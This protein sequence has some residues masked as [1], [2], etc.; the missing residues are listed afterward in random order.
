MKLFCDIISLKGGIDMTKE[1]FYQELEDI[2]RSTDNK[3]RMY[4]KGKD[5]LI[6]YHREQEGC[7]ARFL[8]K[9]FGIDTLSLR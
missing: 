3:E 8:R 2:C 9:Y 4:A 6:Q 1:M 5:L 7:I